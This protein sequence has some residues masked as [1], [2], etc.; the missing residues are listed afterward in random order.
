MTSLFVDIEAQVASP[1]DDEPDYDNDQGFIDDDQPP[2]ND[3][4][5]SVSPNAF[6]PGVVDTAVPFLEDLERRYTG[7]SFR[8]YLGKERLLSS[9]VALGPIHP[10]TKQRLPVCEEPIRLLDLL[11]SRRVL[12]T[13]PNTVEM[14]GLWRNAPPPSGRTHSQS[15]LCSEKRREMRGWSKWAKAE[16]HN[17]AAA[18]FTLGEW[19]SIRHRTYR[20]DTGQIWRA[21]SRQK[22]EHELLSEQQAIHDALK[23]GKTPPDPSPEFVFEGYWVLVVPRLPPPN[24]TQQ[25]SLKLKPHLNK[26]QKRF[27]PMIFNPRQYD[28]AI[29]KKYVRSA[30]GFE[31]DGRL[32]SHGLLI[33]LFRP[34]ALNPAYTVA[35]ETIRAFEN[36][37]HSKRFPFPI[38]GQWCFT[39]GEEVHVDP[40]AGREDGRGVVKQIE[41]GVVCVE[42]GGI[43]NV[44]PAPIPLVRKV[45]NVGDYVRVM[46]SVDVGKEAL[47]VEKHRNVIALSENGSR[48]GIDFFVHIN[49]V[50]RETG[51]FDYSSIPWLDREVTIIKGPLYGRHGTVKDVARHP[52][53]LSLCLW[54]FIPELQKTVQVDDE[55]VVAKGTSEPLWKMFPLSM[56]QKYY[57]VDCIKTNAGEV[58][59]VGLSIVIIAGPH[60]GKKGIVK[61]VNRTQNA[62]AVSGLLVTLE[63]NVMGSPLEQVYYD[64]VREGHTGLTLGG[65]HPLREQEAFFRPKPEFVGAEGSVALESGGG[66]LVIPDLDSYASMDI[67]LPPPVDKSRILDPADE[68]LTIPEFDPEALM[69]V[70]NPY[71]D[72]PGLPEVVPPSAPSPSVSTKPAQRSITQE[73]YEDSARHVLAR[74]NLVG[75]SVLVNI[76]KGWHKKAAVY[77]KLSRT[78]TG[79]IIRLLRKGKGKREHEV[80]LTDLVV[81]NKRVDSAKDDHLLVVI[82][83]V[84]AGKLVRR[85]CHFFVSPEKTPDAKWLVLTVVDRE[86]PVDRLTGEL[87]ECS[88]AELAFV[89]ETP[90]ERFRATHV[91]MKQVRGEAKLRVSAEVRNP[92]EG[93]LECL[94]TVINAQ[95]LLHTARPST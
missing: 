52:N 48:Q 63:L 16:S 12:E 49:S 42:Y 71:W 6:R 88:E 27:S 84:H 20:G 60:K 29:P 79:A 19:V 87:V 9:H 83:G 46:S 77:V 57:N 73:R 67:C 65:Y 22:T 50:T 17:R 54:L 59:W 32:L 23:L 11:D 66:G 70:W 82:G 41:D 13:D 56:D 8:R 35:P 80:S 51:K 81:S 95:F 31:I 58:P 5:A 36:H 92:N 1:S 86:K 30:Q 94:K 38:P 72:Y 39:E 76:Q 47:V 10:L 4:S 55:H 2:N 15:S 53:Q 34:N 75:L 85:I 25:S 28:I 93:N 90:T 37:P 89:E 62:H 61:D 74:P 24:L 3:V 44:H 40:S 33:K 43:R 26:R 14:F 64:Y 68:G 21:H 18:E 69:D 45:I 7:T 91:T 78:P